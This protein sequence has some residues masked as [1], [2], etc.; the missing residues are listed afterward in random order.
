MTYT[1]YKAQRLQKKSIARLKEIHREI[2]CTVEVTDRHCKDT[3]VNAIITHQSSQLE[4][5]H[6]QLTTRLVRNMIWVQKNGRK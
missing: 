3:W 4:K 2:G 1:S 6:K 5:V